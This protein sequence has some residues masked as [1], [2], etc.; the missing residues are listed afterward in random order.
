MVVQHGLSR[1]LA[2]RTVRIARSSLY[3]VGKVKDDA[4]VI[5]AVLAHFQREPGQGSDKLYAAFHPD[6]QRYPWGKTRL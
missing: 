4:P 5:E 6:R 2:C 3:W 1:R